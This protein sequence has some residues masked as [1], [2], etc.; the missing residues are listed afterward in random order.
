M[1][2]I[3]QNIFENVS[4]LKSE[5]NVA[6]YIPQL[7]NV[8]PDLFGLSFCDIHG[9]IYKF[10]DYKNEFS[11]QSCSKPLNY[12]LARTLVENKNE[13]DYYPDNV[14]EHVGYEPSGRSFNEF[15]LNNDSKPH[16]PLINAGAIMVCSL[17]HP[18]G[19]PAQRFDHVKNFYE[20]MSGRIG[21]IGFDNSIFL[22]EKLHADRN[23]SLAYY[24]RENDAFFDKPTP[25]ELNDI[26]DLYFQCCSI[27]VNCEIG[28]VMAATLANA[29]KCPI[30]G[31]DVVDSNIVKDCLSLMFSCGMYDFSGQFSF[32]IGLPAKSGV[33]G[34]LMMV[35][36]NVGGFCIWS[37]RLDSMGNSVN[38]VKFCEQFAEKTKNQYHIFNS[39]QN[40]TECIDDSHVLLQ[41]FIT[42]AANGNVE[43]FQK[44]I[45]KI[46]NVNEKDYDGRTALHL[47]A[48]EGHVKIVDLLLKHNANTKAKDRWGN[49]PFSE[50]SKFDSENYVK[51]KEMLS[52][53]S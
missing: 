46:K 47:A 41:H 48:A 37:P 22:S 30:S 5:G 3:I 51:I 26:L 27:T 13:D 29:G 10:G 36:A 33:S 21:K 12:C 4:K 23:I 25:S 34:C 28:S 32:E 2:S 44:L 49:T 6:S 52:H 42:A 45:S 7:A 9:K 20:S 24:M 53:S 14:H 17:L 31:E 11:I 16:N 1:E 43:N 19:E 18:E 50:A 35:I 15:V 40:E 38:G 8:N 39:K